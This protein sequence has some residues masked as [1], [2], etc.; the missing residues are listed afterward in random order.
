MIPPDVKKILDDL[1]QRTKAG[2]VNWVESNTAGI[3]AL[4]EDD[5][6]VIL[7]DSSINIWKVKGDP[8][9]HVHILDSHGN[10]V[11]DVTGEYIEEFELLDNLL[12]AAGRK[13]LNIDETL[14]VIKRNLSKPGVLGNPN[15]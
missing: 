11:L 15:P 7:P 8:T 4:A 10:I 3:E 1:L 13:A 14:E 6:V 12:Q 5:Y 9:I 2:E